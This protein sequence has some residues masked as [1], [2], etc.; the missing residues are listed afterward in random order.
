MFYLLT[1]LSWDRLIFIPASFSLFNINVPSWLWVP[2]ASL[3]SIGIYLLWRRSRPSEDVDSTG[4]VPRADTKSVIEFNRYA[5][6]HPDIDIDILPC[7]VFI[8]QDFIHLCRYQDAERK[9]L[10]SLGKIPMNEIREFRVEDVFTMK[11]KLSPENWDLTIRHLL[12]LN[13]RKGSEVAFVVI[14]WV[15]QGKTINTYL[16][17]EGEYAMEWALGKRNLLVKAGRKEVLQFA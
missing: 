9:Q 4:S 2:A 1:C 5:G 10:G 11:R 13:Q 6:G 14:E 12:D 7:V 15:F 16:C 17:I 3:I 8:E